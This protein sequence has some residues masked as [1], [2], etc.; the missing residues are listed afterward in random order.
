MVSLPIVPIKI[1]LQP[2]IKNIL[3]HTSSTHGI[4]SKTPTPHQFHLLPAMSEHMWLEQLEKNTEPCSLVPSSIHHHWSQVGPWCCPRPSVT[5]GWQA[6]PG[7]VNSL[8]K[9]AAHS[10]LWAALPLTS[11]WSMRTKLQCCPGSGTSSLHQASS[12]MR[13]WQRSHLCSAHPV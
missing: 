12:T 9:T 4:H 13:Q 8:G 2:I 5:L 7:S 10:C 6:L 1:H 11:S 3:F